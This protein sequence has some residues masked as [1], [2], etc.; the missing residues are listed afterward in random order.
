MINYDKLINKEYIKN[1]DIFKQPNFRYYSNFD[2]SSIFQMKNAYITSIF[3]SEDYIPSALVLAQS[4]RNVNTKY[5]IICMVQDKPY[6]VNKNTTFKGISEKGIKDLL[7]LF[8]MVIGVDLLKVKNFEK[9]NRYSHFTNI[10][11]Y[12]NILYYVTKGQILALTQFK[13]IFYLDASTY[14]GKNIDFIFNKYNK[15]NFHYDIEFKKTKVG[16]RGTYLFLIPKITYYYKLLSFI[17]NYSK[18][19]G[20]LYFCRGIDELLIF[21]SIFPHWDKLKM[22]FNFTCS[23]R[24]NRPTCDIS[25]FQVI[26]PFRKKPD[27]KKYNDIPDEIFY[28]WNGI[29][30]SILHKKPN[31]SSY[32]KHIPEFRKQQIFI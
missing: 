16:Y 17:K 25:Y 6:E 1:P 3:I 12:K 20:K 23:K 30:K 11:S 2:L 28:E 22:P 9:N 24:I 32:Y 26:K 18:F 7:E 8:D 29:A 31:L 10:P 27:G 4:L 14:V 13:K 21:Y 15:P 5:P 19:F